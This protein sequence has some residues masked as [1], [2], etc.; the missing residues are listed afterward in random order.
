MNTTTDSLI[1]T[2][3][4]DLT[5]KLL[6]N[7]QVK[8][9]RLAAQ[10]EISVSEFRT[11]RVFRNEN[12]LHIKDLIGRIDL[13][14]SRLTR[15]LDNLEEKKFLKR[16]LDPGNRR[17]MIVALTPKGASLVHELEHRYIQIHEEILE[18]IPEELHENLIV[19][20]QKMLESLERWLRES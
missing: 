17:S 13:S 9:E 7:C 1:P 5:F 18:G 6:S 15:I 16:T 12:Q 3:I 14:A 10:F 20:L 4:A 19:G 2:Q 8:E 11:L